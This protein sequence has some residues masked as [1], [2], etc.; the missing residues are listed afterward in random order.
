MLNNVYHD[1]NDDISSSGT[2][3]TWNKKATVS[4]FWLGRSGTTTKDAF[5]LTNCFPIKFMKN[6]SERPQTKIFAL[7]PLPRSA[8]QADASYTFVL[9]LPPLNCDV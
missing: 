8:Q 1:A 9:V 2:L 4:V 6:P 5:Y 3:D 7:S